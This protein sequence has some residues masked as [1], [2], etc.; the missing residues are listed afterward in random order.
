MQK[1]ESN[2]IHPNAPAGSGGPG[3]FRSASPLGT[4]PS[5]DKWLSPSMDKRFSPAPLA[6]N[7]K[8]DDDPKIIRLRQIRQLVK[9][10]NLSTLDENVIICQ[11]YMESR[12]DAKAGVS[13]DAKGLMQMQKNAVRQVYKYRKQKKLGHMPSDKVTAE[14]FKEADKFHDSP[15]IFDEAT[16][17]QLGT[18]YMQYWLDTTKTPEEAYKKYRGKADGVYYKKIKATADKLSKDPDSMQILID[19]VK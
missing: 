12:F 18:E 14:V 15:S 6:S 2:D 7:L 4:N 9:E 8:K 11:I 1:K 17:I 5:M 19:M 3:A 13:H 16:N 10:N